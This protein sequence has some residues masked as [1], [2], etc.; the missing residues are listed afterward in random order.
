MS[1]EVTTEETEDSGTVNVNLSA[2]FRGTNGSNVVEAT[3]I[4]GDPERPNIMI[5][6][7]T[8]SDGSIDVSVDSTGFD[9]ETLLGFLEEL[10]VKMRETK[11]YELLPDGTVRPAS[12][13]RKE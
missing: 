3:V 10:I 5:G 7:E 12:F 8:N 1:E 6:F 4:L 13:Q 11:A 9:P 2:T